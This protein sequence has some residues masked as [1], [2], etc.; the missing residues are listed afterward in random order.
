MQR[1]TEVKMIANASTII[2]KVEISIRCL[3]GYKT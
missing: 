3:L 2:K 1:T